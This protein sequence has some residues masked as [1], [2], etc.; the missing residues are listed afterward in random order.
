MPVRKK[1]L[2]VKAKYQKTL[3]NF[4]KCMS[5]NT[6]KQIR[7]TRAYKELVPFGSYKNKSN[8]YHFGRKSSMKKRDLCRALSNPKAYH[9][10]VKEKYGTGKRKGVGKMKNSAKRKRYSRLGNCTPASGPK[11]RTEPCTGAFKNRGIT[12]TA[13]KCCYKKPMSAATKRKRRSNAKAKKAAKTRY[14]SQSIITE[15]KGRS[16]RRRR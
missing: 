1:S 13:K 12:T 15:G 10:K 14:N 3:M 8:A 2:Q 7:K 11:K 16:R 9:K 4:N 6:L 5:E